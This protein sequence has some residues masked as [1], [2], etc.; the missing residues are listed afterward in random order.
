MFA[1]IPYDWASAVYEMC[2]N[3]LDFKTVYERAAQLV[4]EGG[5]KAVEEW[6]SKL[7]EDGEA[8]NV[9]YTELGQDC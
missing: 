7:D 4:N 9:Y 6:N 2:S 5:R 3:D 8:D 1:L